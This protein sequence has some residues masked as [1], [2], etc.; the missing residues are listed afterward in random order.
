MKQV[1]ILAATIFILASCNNGNAKQ[2]FKPKADTVK[3][4]GTY[5]DFPSKNIDHAFVYEILTNTVAVDSFLKVT[6]KI[7]TARYILPSVDRIA[8]SYIYKKT[9]FGSVVYDINVDSAF[10]KLRR[11]IEANDHLFIKDSTV[12][13]STGKQ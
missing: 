5:V 13:D 1:L 9:P 3:L 4:W 6:T 11:W 8:G 12:I 2:V 7:D 10:A